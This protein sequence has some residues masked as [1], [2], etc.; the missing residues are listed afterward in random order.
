MV[1]DNHK[2]YGL[3]RYVPSRRLMDFDAAYYNLMYSNFRSENQIEFT[4]LSSY[5]KRMEFIRSFE[6]IG[7]LN[8]RIFKTSKCQWGSLQDNEIGRKIEEQIWP[9]QP[10]QKP[11]LVKERVLDLPEFKTGFHLSQTIEWGKNDIIATS[12]KNKI[13]TGSGFTEKYTSTETVTEYEGDFGTAVAWSGNGVNLAVGTDAG[14]VQIWNL[15]KKKVIVEEK[16]CEEK[17]T[18]TSLQWHPMHHSLVWA[19][20]RGKISRRDFRENITTE[21]EFAHDGCICNLKYSPKAN[22]LCSSG[23]DGYVRIW[24]GDSCDPY[25]EIEMSNPVRAIAWH[26]WRSGLLAVGEGQPGTGSLSIWNVNTAKMQYL[27]KMSKSVAI[28]TMEFSKISGELVYAQW[29]VAEGEEDHCEIVVL[30]GTNR[31][32]DVSHQGN[33]YVTSLLWS[34]DGEKLGTAG[35]DETFKIFKF[36]EPRENRKRKRSTNHGLMAFNECHTTVR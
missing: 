12:V 23:Q 34:P 2:I 27:G 28:K 32:V 13:I 4:S 5:N 31:V 14:L 20:S 11:C 36:Y 35:T 6:N 26:P 25:M 21:V 9:C 18:V 7:N 29:V 8:Q 3:D 17:C 1:Q 15:T 10:R 24:R 22:Y 30:G 16:C 33:G 19:C